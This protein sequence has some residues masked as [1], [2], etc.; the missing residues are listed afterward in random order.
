MLTRGLQGM[1]MASS[2]P[3]TAAA[4]EE[5]LRGW[6]A[7]V[8]RLEGLAQQVCFAGHFGLRIAGGW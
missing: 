6:E 3:A 2:Q 1:L 8:A 4:L 7:D 5:Q